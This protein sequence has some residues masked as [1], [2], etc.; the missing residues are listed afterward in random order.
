MLNSI[1]AGCVG[2]TKLS[3]VKVTE[4]YH[5]W[6]KINH[7]EAYSNPKLSAKAGVV[8]WFNH[9]LQHPEIFK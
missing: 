9:L 1:Y 7:P 6:V 3:E 4:L 5:L 8:N 2:K